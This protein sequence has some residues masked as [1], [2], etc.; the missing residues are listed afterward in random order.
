M[1]PQGFKLPKQFLSQLG[2][3]SRGY[4]L[5]IV[6]DRGEI[7][8]FESYDNPTIRLG[9]LNF[10]DAQASA[11]Q[12]NLRNQALHMEEMGNREDPRPPKPGGPDDE[13]EDYN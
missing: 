11:A 10:V 2:E 3:F 6:N 4:Y 7:E 12:E 9:L 13:D 5:A 8:S 1:N